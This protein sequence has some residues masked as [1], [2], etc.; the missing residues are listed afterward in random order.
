MPIF[1]LAIFNYKLATLLL[2]L[3]ALGIYLGV[4]SRREILKHIFYNAAA[5]LVAVGIFEGYLTK[6]ELKMSEFHIYEELVEDQNGGHHFRDSEPL[7][8]KPPEQ[9]TFHA[10]KKI[11]TIGEVVYDAR[12]TFEDGIRSTPSSSASGIDCIHFFGCSFTF[13]HGLDDTATLPHYMGDFT[14]HPFKIVNHGF[15]GYGLHQVMR[16]IEQLVENDQSC[17]GRKIAIYPHLFGHISRAAGYSTWDR[18]GPHYELDN[19]K[20][21][22]LGPFED[23][24]SFWVNYVDPILEKSRIYKK[25]YKQYFRSITDQDIE[26]GLAIML[27]CNKILSESGIEF[28]VFIYDI[29]DHIV[30]DFGSQARYEKAIRILQEANVR[31]H[32]LSD[33]IADYDENMDDYTI[34]IHD[35][36]PNARS[37]KLVA[38]YFSTLY[39][40]EGISLSTNHQSE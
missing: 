33:V 25:F 26:R 19:G 3:A 12:Y 36:H 28:E 24:T 20:L 35:R 7:G 2:V 8:Y 1:I 34:S 6:Q 39:N 4:R 16:Q 27:Q 5:I 18:F 37:N 40:Q 31:L 11:R 21:K 29:N 14:N 38:T 10:Q 30:G 22:N 13:G 32:F 17:R 23:R 15:D 9:G